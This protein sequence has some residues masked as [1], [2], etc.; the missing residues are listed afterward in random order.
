MLSLALAVLAALGNATASVLQRKADREEPEGQAAG[1]VLLWHLAHRP[2]WLGGIA[3]LIV[4]F[5]LQAAALS[6]GAIALVQP[7]L[8]LELAFTLLLASMVFRSQLHARE[9]TAIIGMTIG[10]ASMLF[11][12]QPGGG[13]P[14]RASTAG[15]ATGIGVSLAV[16]GLFV[17][18][19]YRTHGIHRAAYL[20]LA[21]GIGFGFIAALIAGIGAAYGASGIGGLFRTPQTYLVIV[22][23][24]AFFFLLQKTLQAGLLVASQPALTLSNPLVSVT[25][26]VAVFDE[27]LRTGAWLILALFGAA[28][29][30]ACTVLLAHSP[31]LHS[32]ERTESS[33]DSQ[34]TS[35]TPPHRD[36]RKRTDLQ[37]S[38]RRGGTS[39][40]HNSP[41]RSASSR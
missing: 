37:G 3:A 41:D 25:F 1:L 17:V 22:L 20:G 36:P 27:H 21:T 23:G 11:A 34:P 18:I 8:V 38:R 9:W 15:W 7:I 16:A 40:V 26:G 12:L 29:I 31:L 39:R 19:G 33:A 24:P 6:T 4:A 28:L 10:L 32:S 5:L 14:T 30:I 13:D 2:A 35:A